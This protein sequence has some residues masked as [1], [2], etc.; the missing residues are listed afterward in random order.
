MFRL[1]ADAWGKPA[2]DM[3]KRGVSTLKV[4]IK[5]CGAFQRKKQRMYLKFL[6]EMS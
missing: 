3:I 1:I 4:L 6:K 5:E 2:V